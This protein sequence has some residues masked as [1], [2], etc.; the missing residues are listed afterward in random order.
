MIGIP[1]GAPTA[2]SAWRGCGE[3]T[4]CD[5]AQEAGLW[6][7]VG[8]R[9]W[10]ERWAGPAWQVALLTAWAPLPPGAALCFSCLRSVVPSALQGPEKGATTGDPAAWSC[11]SQG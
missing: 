4:R 7:V 1:K 11:S 9:P 8:E 10:A 5:Q 2:R 3:G 6:S